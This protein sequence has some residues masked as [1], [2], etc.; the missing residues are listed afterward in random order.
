M[1]R[2]RW[3]TYEPR[4]GSGG[5]YRVAVQPCGATRPNRTA[6]GLTMHD[7]QRKLR[8]RREVKLGDDV[9]RLLVRGTLD[10]LAGHVIATVKKACGCCGAATGKLALKQDAHAKAGRKLRLKALRLNPARLP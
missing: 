9:L 10:P 2:R 8:H 3:I 5:A 4:P 1:S 7:G 6:A